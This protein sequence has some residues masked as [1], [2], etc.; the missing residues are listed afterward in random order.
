VKSQ[1][2]DV[3]GRTDEYVKARFDFIADSIKRNAVDPFTV[4]ARDGITA[5]GL[6]TRDAPDTAYRQMIA[7]M[8]NAHKSPGDTNH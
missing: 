4:V 6:S 3:A 8:K 2:G 1:G 7:D 5:N